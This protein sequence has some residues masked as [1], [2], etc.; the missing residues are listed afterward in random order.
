MPPG[1]PEPTRARQERPRATGEGG[2]GR[3]GNVVGVEL[4][5]LLKELHARGNEGVRGVELRGGAKRIHPVS[6]ATTERASA[7]RQ[8][9]TGLLLEYP[10][11]TSL[12]AAPPGPALAFLGFFSPWGL[13]SLRTSLTGLTLTSFSTT[14]CL[15]SAGLASAAWAAA[16]GG[17]PATGASAAGGRA[18]D[19]GRRKA[20]RRRRGEG[21][22]G[23]AVVSRGLQA[24]RRSMQLWKGRG[25]CGYESTE[26]SRRG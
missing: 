22:V 16:A 20:A 23:R 6:P 10:R 11:L 14:A 21:W 4:L 17:M 18:D 19:M 26:G 2:G 7:A 1:L 24:R 15:T 5:P 13:T 8:G 9:W 3:T 12:P 25:R